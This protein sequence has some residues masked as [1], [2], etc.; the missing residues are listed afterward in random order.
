MNL[1]HFWIV[2]VVAAMLMAGCTSQDVI[3]FDP[4]LKVGDTRDC[5]DSME[6]ASDADKALF[7]WCDQPSDSKHCCTSVVRKMHC[8]SYNCDGSRCAAWCAAN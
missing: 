4:G 8:H 2:A 1:H 5:P 6:D 7:W 3:Y